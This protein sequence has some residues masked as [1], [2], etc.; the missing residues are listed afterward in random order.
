MTELDAELA[1]RKLAT[2]TRNLSLLATI[3]G[4]TLAEY[5]ACAIL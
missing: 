4:L 5:R 1:R 2:I 3:E